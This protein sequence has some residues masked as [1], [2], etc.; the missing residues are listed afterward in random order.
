MQFFLNLSVLARVVSASLHE[1]V[2][3]DRMDHIL[4]LFLQHVVS[5]RH[6]LYKGEFI[7]LDIVL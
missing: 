1:V 6:I 3:L 5:L 7:I 4:H 2:L